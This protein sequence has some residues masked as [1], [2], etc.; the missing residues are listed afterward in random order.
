MAS[1]PQTPKFE[2]K[3]VQFLVILGVGGHPRKHLE[4][5]LGQECR[6]KRF[7]EMPRPLFGYIG[8]LRASHW[9]PQIGS[10]RGRYAKTLVKRS[11]SHVQCYRAGFHIANRWLRLV[12]LA[13]KHK[14]MGPQ[15]GPTTAIFSRKGRQKVPKATH[16]EVPRVSRTAFW[17]QVWRLSG[18]TEAPLHFPDF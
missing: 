12:V 15:Q 7:L 3:F 6:L 18:R 1:W 4:T 9:S 5:P 2:S 16:F 10:G 13:L 8:G 14:I 17:R 11:A